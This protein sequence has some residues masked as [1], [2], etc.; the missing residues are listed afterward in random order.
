M[1]KIKWQMTSKVLIALATLLV[2]VGLFT[3]I[4]PAAKASPP[5]P[6]DQ[7][8]LESKALAIAQ[9]NGLQGNPTAKKVVRMTLG[10]WLALD[11]GE[12]GTDA[13]QIGLTP[14]LPV[15]VLAIRGNVTWRGLGMVP[16]NQHYDS[17]TVVIDA[18]TGEI[19]QV[20]AGPS[21]HMPVP[22]P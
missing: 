4:H 15:F 14:D 22:V 18:R 6:L 17:I 8:I 7:S 12:L 21:D 9:L 5:V 16:S 10:E 13:A 11:G 1:T 2:L 3:L 20:G 19:M